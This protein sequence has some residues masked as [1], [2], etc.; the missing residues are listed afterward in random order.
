MYKR[1]LDWLI[2]VRKLHP[3]VI[4]RMRLGYH[5]GEERETWGKTPVYLP[6][7]IV[8]PWWSGGTIQKINLRPP[9]PI[10][11]RK[12]TLVSGSAN[13]IY[14]LDALNGWSPVIM[15][16]G[17]MNA[18]AI[19]SATDE[20]IPVATGAVSWGRAFPWV[21]KLAAQPEIILAFDQDEAGRSCTAWWRDHL[22][23]AETIDLPEGV[24]DANELAQHDPQGIVRW[25]ERFSARTENRV[26]EAL[27]IRIREEMG[28]AGWKLTPITV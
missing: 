12:Y 22:P 11:G 17:E 2:E 18:L 1:Q 6:R 4:R 28:A 23:H 16:E 20:F 3:D 14:N 8:I 5:N 13:G 19:L 26:S 27:K 21:V 25:L 15:V 24:K 10:G 7:S 9:E